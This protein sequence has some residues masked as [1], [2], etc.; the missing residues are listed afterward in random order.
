MPKTALNTSPTACRGGRV[1]SACWAF[2]G[3]HLLGKAGSTGINL[4]SRQWELRNVNVTPFL[5]PLSRV[6]FTSREL[7]WVFSLAG[8]P[9]AKCCRP[10]EDARASVTAKPGKV[11]ASTKSEAYSTFFWGRGSFGFTAFHLLASFVA[12]GSRWNRS[13]KGRSVILDM[14]KHLNPSSW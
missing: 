5:H 9:T 8:L 3:I 4:K 7:P 6:I 12:M 10:G 14:G 11:E 13:Q 1:W 2:S